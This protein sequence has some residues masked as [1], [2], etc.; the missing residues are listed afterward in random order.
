M[1]REGAREGGDWLMGA[2]GHCPAAAPDL[3]CCSS[4][5]YSV[6]LE[7]VV[8]EGPE[9][10]SPKDFVDDEKESRGGVFDGTVA[11]TTPSLV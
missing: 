10:V 5:P 11:H 3:A 6:A 4:Q 7:E 1:G 8:D 9:A 2:D